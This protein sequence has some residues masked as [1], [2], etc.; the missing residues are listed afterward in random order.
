MGERAAG[1]TC[2]RRDSSEGG[3]VFALRARGGFAQSLSENGER[4]CGWGILG[5]ARRWAAGQTSCGLFR[6]NQRSPSRKDPPPGGFGRE[7]P[8]SGV[9]CRSQT[10][11]G[12]L[13][14]RALPIELFPPKQDPSPFSD[15][16]LDSTALFGP[17]RGRWVLCQR[18]SGRSKGILSVWNPWFCRGAFDSRMSDSVHS[19]F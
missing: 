9:A 13:P 14:L 4:A 15:R 5:W 18:R 19:L 12:L 10:A 1:R 3:R 7:G 17:S 6:P 16:I 11:A 2:V 8:A